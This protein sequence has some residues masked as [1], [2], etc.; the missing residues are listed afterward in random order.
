M[1]TTVAGKK[2]NVRGLTRG[3]LSLLEAEGIQPDAVAQIEAMAAREAAMDRVLSMA[4][5]ELDTTTLT[6]AEYMEVYAQV[7][8][9]TYLGEGALKK[10]AALL[11]NGSAGAST[12][13]APAKNKAA[14]RS[15]GKGGAR[16]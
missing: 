4:I 13:A 16:R 8:Q 10:F 14:K 6:P 2:M 5:P 1:E 7:V 3:E 12:P 11:E 15:K 9:L